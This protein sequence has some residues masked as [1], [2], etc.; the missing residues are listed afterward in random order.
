MISCDY[1]VRAVD[2]KGV[3]PCGKEATHSCLVECI[4]E[5]GA[6]SRHEHRCAD[7]IKTADV[8]EAWTFEEMTDWI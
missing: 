5:E 3:M 8:I 4:G 6:Q 2:G 1:K 7:H